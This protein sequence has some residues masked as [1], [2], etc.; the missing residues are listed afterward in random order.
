MASPGKDLWWAKYGECL[1]YVGGAMVTP[2]RT[3]EVV[4]R[5]W[6]VDGYETAWNDIW[7]VLTV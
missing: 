4:W 5:M 2:V 3:H 1:Q 7:K 6:L